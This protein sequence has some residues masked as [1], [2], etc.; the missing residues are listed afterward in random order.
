MTDAS[1]R[2][3]DPAAFDPPDEPKTGPAARPRLAAT[4]VLA[5]QGRD[6]PEL[7][8]GRRAAGHRFMPGKFV[9][10]G[11]RVDREDARAP[12][13]GELGAPSRDAILRHLGPARARALPRTA[14]RETFEETG[15]LVGAP[16]AL[17]PAKRAAGPC[18]RA[19]EAAGLAPAA[20][21]LALI[22]RAVT[23]PDRPLRFDAWFFLAD[24]DAALTPRAA[25]A[26]PEL[27]DVG[28]YGLQE[29][30]RLDLPGVTRF[31]L[32]VIARRLVGADAI[33][34]V[35]Y[36]RIVRGRRRIETL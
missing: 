14:L 5:R 27:S 10:P 7:L 34:P 11:G 12:A 33:D 13:D 2:D 21:R 9:F 16:G 18:W 17:A 3:A 1:L 24:A 19:Y 8:M 25:E 26:S 15:M 36:L 23:P 29:A 4:L 28:W 20:S 30:A 31:M 32:G 35:P 22:A 6:G